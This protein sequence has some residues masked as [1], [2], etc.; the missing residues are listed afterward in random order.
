MN[1][2]I[3]PIGET[4]CVVAVALA[5]TANGVVPLLIDLTA[6]GA[7]PF[8]FNGVISG[9]VAG[10]ALVFLKVSSRVAFG[11]SLSYREVWRPGTA[12]LCWDRGASPPSARAP[13]GVRDWA[14]TPVV[15]G[16]VGSLALAAFTMAVRYVDTAVVVAIFQLWTLLA[17]LLLGRLGRL[18]AVGDHRPHRITPR[19]TLLAG[20]AFA[21]AVFVVLSETAHV[22]L[23]SR[24]A[25]LFGLGWAFLSA[26]LASLVVPTSVSMGHLAH[27]HAWRGANPAGSKE[28]QLA[29]CAIYGVLWIK[30]SG[31][32]L[33]FGLG[34]FSVALGHGV[35]LGRSALFGA[36]LIAALGLAATVL[37]RW[38]LHSSPNLGHQASNYLAP[39]VSLTL[40]A[41][42]TELSVERLDLL[43][44]GVGLI[45]AANV[46]I[47]PKPTPASGAP[48]GPRLTGRR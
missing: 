25:A 8:I 22:G 32:L 35:A 7:N 37:V 45:V 11:R 10:L 19:Q 38:A 2:G 30:A 5:A 4:G 28:L 13:R 14:R 43:L 31:A 41:V 48:D 46:L 33:N 29:W 34:G 47:R 17:V 1:S 42:F 9:S 3:R 16:A 6:L 39:V 18:L 15:W 27:A 21:G 36:L 24:W 40:L 12:W 20:V 26:L 44:V 23:S